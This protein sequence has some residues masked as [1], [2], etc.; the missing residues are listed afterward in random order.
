MGLELQRQ[1]Y[2][3]LSNL[4]LQIDFWFDLMN[5]GLRDHKRKL[6][7]HMAP[8]ESVDDQRLGWLRSF[9]SMLDFLLAFLN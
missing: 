9:P 4:I 1:G 3:H 2:K 8:Y 7:P 6:K 5:T